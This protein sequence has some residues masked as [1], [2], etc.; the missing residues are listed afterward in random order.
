MIESVQVL[1]GPLDAF[2]DLLTNDQKRGLQS[3]AEDRGHNRAGTNLTEMCSRSARHFT[4]LPSDQIEQTVQPN[5]RQNSAL[6][7][8]KTASS[9]AADIL[10]GTCPS[11][12]LSTPEVRLDAMAK[13]LHAMAEAVKTMRPA[14]QTFYASLDDEQK[15]RFN[16]MNEQQ[17]QG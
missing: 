4:R 7:A 11:R 2:Y 1:R 3:M 15:A 16:T 12:I 13:R 17:R 9:K 10:N 14:L 6:E 5:G 8:L